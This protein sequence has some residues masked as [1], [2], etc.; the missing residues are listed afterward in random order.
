VEYLHALTGV[1]AYALICA[2]IFIE[3]AGVP[4][5]FLPGDVI[6][7]AAGYLAAI[8]VTHLWLFLPLGYAAAVLGAT[9]CYAF[10]RHVGRRALLAAAQLVRLTPVRLARAE[11]WLSRGGSRA[12]LIARI[13]PGT[14]INASFAAG[15]L[16][17]PYEEFIA[18]V[19]PS[20][21]IWLGGFTLLGFALGDRVTPFLPW[22]DRLVVAGVVIGLL[23]GLVVWRR[24][25]RA[26][27]GPTPVNLAA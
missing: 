27:R 14:R 21:M 5:P 7:L 6:L 25:R 12:I 19:L 16:R 13:L 1:E 8:G 24:R 10:S 15:G 20:T 17:L 26:N 18:G 2:L 3:E 22:F 9:T 4:L 11:A 23:V